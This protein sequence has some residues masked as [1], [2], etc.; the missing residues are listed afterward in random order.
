MS[1]TARKGELPNL[2]PRRQERVFE[3]NSGW[4]VTTREG[5]YVGP[6]PTKMV[7]GEAAKELTGILDGV[8]DVKVGEAFVREFARRTVGANWWV[9]A[10]GWRTANAS[11]QTNG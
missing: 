4:Y 6:Y 7:A 3:V 8:D 9:Q 2:R 11:T 5:I 1:H 10:T